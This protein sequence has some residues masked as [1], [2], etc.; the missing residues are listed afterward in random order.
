MGIVT[1]QFLLGLIRE[2]QWWKPGEGWIGF[3]FLLGLIG[4]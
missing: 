1:F 3:Q 4:I 2:L